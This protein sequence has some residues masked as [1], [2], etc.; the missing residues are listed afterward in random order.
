M[1]AIDKLLFFYSGNALLQEEYFQNI[2]R[3]VVPFLITQFLK[4]EEVIDSEMDVN[5][6]AYE[7]G[8]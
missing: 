3:N 2:L 7:K 8:K 5:D 4:S 6:T 1:E